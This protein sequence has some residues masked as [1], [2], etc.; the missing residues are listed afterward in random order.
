[1]TITPNATPPS[2]VPTIT[3]TLT[4]CELSPDPPFC[5]RDGLE[6]LPSMMMMV[7]APPGVAAGD[8]GAFVEWAEVRGREAVVEVAVRVVGRDVVVEVAVEVRD[9][10]DE[11]I[12]L[13]V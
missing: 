13:E 5:D 8:F 6:G 12:V 4:A 1:M 3:G 10:A 7:V 2:A 11:G 9:R